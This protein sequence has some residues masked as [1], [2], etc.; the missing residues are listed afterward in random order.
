MDKWIGG[1][2]YRWMGGSV[3][4]GLVEGWMG[5]K[6]DGYRLARFVMF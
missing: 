4:G 5:G 6:F 1:W 2:V 3:D